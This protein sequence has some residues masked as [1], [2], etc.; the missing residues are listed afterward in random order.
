MTEECDY[1]DFEL[2][3]QGVSADWPLKKTIAR[4]ALL[5]PRRPLLRRGNIP[6]LV[7]PACSAAMGEL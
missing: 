4:P 2:K 1:L 7:T 3:G 5:T 6:A